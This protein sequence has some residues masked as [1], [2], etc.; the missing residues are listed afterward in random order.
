MGKQRAVH[1]DDRSMDIDDVPVNG[2]IDEHSRNGDPV[3]KPSG[4][5]AVSA[6][7]PSS[8]QR[9]KYL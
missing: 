2:D 3:L 8:L 4:T 5:D 1:F 7:Q 6:F 9:V